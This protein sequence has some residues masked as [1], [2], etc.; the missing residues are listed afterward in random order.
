VNAVKTNPALDAGSRPAK[1]GAGRLH[2]R[3]SSRRLFI[4]PP[5]E[6]LVAMCGSE[7]ARNSLQN[8]ALVGTAC[9]A[10]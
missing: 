7:L 6:R 2:S 9:R 10:N 8:A 5:D 4:T 1:E 3:R